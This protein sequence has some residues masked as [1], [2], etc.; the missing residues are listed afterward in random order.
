MLLRQL[1]ESVA[2]LELINAH[3]LHRQNAPLT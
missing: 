1:H 2:I 3:V